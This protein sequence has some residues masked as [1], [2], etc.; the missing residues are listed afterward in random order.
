MKKETAKDVTFNAEV[1]NGMN[2]IDLSSLDMFS[3]IRLCYFLENKDFL[4]EM[5]PNSCLLCAAVIGRNGAQG[6]DPWSEMGVHA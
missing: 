5:Y 2:S 4:F 1:R 3:N 6:N